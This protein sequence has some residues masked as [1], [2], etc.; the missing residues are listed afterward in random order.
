MKT[1][2]Q[3]IKYLSV[4]GNNASAYIIQ[5]GFVSIKITLKNVDIII[6]DEHY[7]NMYLIFTKYSDLAQALL[8]TRNEARLVDQA[9][10]YC[11][12]LHQHKAV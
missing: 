11:L 8:G 4:L 9:H 2:K 5:H 10:A 12:G 6:T 7:K 1:L 3:C